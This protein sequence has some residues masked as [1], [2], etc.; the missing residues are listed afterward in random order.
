MSWKTFYSIV[1]C[2]VLFSLVSPSAV[3]AGPFRD[4]AE[5]A[6]AT[7]GGVKHRLVVTDAN[8]KRVGTVVG[9]LNVTDL[10]VAL[11]FSRVDFVIGV[12]Q[13]GFD[14]SSFQLLG[15]L[16]TDCT[17]QAYIYAGNGVGILPGVAVA[18]PGQTVYVES[19]APAA[20]TVNSTFRDG[21]CSTG[22]FTSQSAAAT[23]L[24]DLSTQFSAPFTASLK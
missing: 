23:A 18:A 12:G 3:A 21:A 6:S 7:A 15:F 13:G 22:A 11:S 20:L 5:E 4:R 9:V 2:A 24:V 16:S 8:G 10:Y 17:G 14:P 1:C 19:G